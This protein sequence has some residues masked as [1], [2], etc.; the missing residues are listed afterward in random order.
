MRK[1]REKVPYRKPS[2]RNPML[3]IPT[4][5]ARRAKVLAAER[6]ADSRLRTALDNPTNARGKPVAAHLL[7]KIAAECLI[8]REGSNHNRAFDFA[9]K[10]FMQKLNYQWGCAPSI[11]ALWKTF[12]SLV[13]EVDPDCAAGFA[14]N[15]ASAFR[16]CL[17]GHVHRLDMERDA[18]PNSIVVVEIWKTRTGDIAVGIQRDGRRRLI[19]TDQPP[20]IPMIIFAGSKIHHFPASQDLKRIEK[21]VKEIGERRLFAELESG[22]FK[23]SARPVA[24]VDED[25]VLNVARPADDDLAAI[26]QALSILSFIQRRRAKPNP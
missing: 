20:D 5:A 22:R 18:L 23:F 3:D 8:T 14:K 12:L 26:R 15:Y 13:A 7:K 21:M 19:P 17:A 9:T 4:E 2:K 6:E 11:S 25:A 10:A 16:W 24:L 1:P